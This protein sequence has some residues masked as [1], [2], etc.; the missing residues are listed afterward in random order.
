[1]SAINKVG[2][3]PFLLI[4]EGSNTVFIDDFEGVVLINQL[5]G[6]SVFEDTD[7]FHINAAS[8]E[9]WHEFVHYCLSKSIFGFENLA[10]I[11]GTV[12]A[13][14]IQNIGAY[15]VE[16]ESFVHSVEFIDVETGMMVYF[17]NKECEFS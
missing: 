1:M 10:L 14:P 5:K 16:I 12:G 15:G 7:F 11:P 2:D 4:G 17:N 3:M 8:G 9:N 13:A 6:I